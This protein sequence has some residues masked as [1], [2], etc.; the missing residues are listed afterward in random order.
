MFISVTPLRKNGFRREQRD[1]RTDAQICG[2]F[3]ILDRRIS[4]TQTRKAAELRKRGVVNADDSNL[5]AVLYEPQLKSWRGGTF[6]LTGW[7]IIDWLDTGRQIVI[8]EW[9]CR[10]EGF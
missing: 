8:Q 9:A 10:I 6:N 4:A 3:C 2:D 7:E 5:L 1:L